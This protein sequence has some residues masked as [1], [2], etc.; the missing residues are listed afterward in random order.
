MK[1]TQN[2]SSRYFYFHK[3]F[4]L[5]EENRILNKVKIVFNTVPILKQNIYQHIAK[6][7]TPLP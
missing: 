1:I 6:T 5:N 3:I 2:I 4:I 7:K